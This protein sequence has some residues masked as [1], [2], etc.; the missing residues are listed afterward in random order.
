MLPET[1]R[2]FPLPVQSVNQVVQTLS[3]VVCSPFVCS[4]WNGKGNSILTNACPWGCSSSCNIFET[5]STALEWIAKDKL[6]A[7]SVI[8]IL[9]NF[10]FIG[11]SEAKCQ[12][13]LDNFLCVCCRIGVP[14]AG[15]KT[16][17]PTNAL[18]F[19]A[20][21]LDMALMEARLP[22]DKLVKCHTHLADFCSQKSFNLK[23]LQSLI[24]LLNFACCAVV[25]VLFCTV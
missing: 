24:G 18:Q 9:D 4:G 10:L 8:H 13:D 23:E 17:G 21:T 15:E 20:I 12:E 14:I 19:A 5:F 16:M 7:S 1:V 25:T 22:E 6:Q 11:P 2:N 3:E